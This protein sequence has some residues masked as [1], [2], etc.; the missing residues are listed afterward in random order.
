[1]SRCSGEIAERLF[2]KWPIGVLIPSQRT[3]L[4]SR[5]FTIRD[6]QEHT[7]KSSA[8]GK[9][10]KCRRAEQSERRNN[11]EGRITKTAAKMDGTMNKM[12]A[13]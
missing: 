11:Q 1:M 9:R 13:N 7:A 4:V 5:A 8:L 12:A 6:Y 2:A 10:R 3:T